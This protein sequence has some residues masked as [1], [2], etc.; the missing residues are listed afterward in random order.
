MQEVTFRPHTFWRI[1]IALALL[2]VLG[3]LAGVVVVAYLV[4]RGSATARTPNDPERRRGP[5]S[6]GRMNGERAEWEPS[7]EEIQARPRIEAG[8][9]RPGHGYWFEV[10]GESH[11]QR[12]LRAADGGRLA[13]G[14]Y[15]QVPCLIVPE[16]LNPYDKN[17][18]AVYIDGQGKVGHSSREDATEY[19]TLARR[20]IEQGA[21][22][23]C[24]GNLIGGQDETTSIGV[25]LSIKE[26]G[27]GSNATARLTELITTAVYVSGWESKPRVTSGPG[28]KFSFAV[29]EE[30]RFQE[31]LRQ[32]DGGRLATGETVTFA[33]LIVPEPAHPGRPGSIL[34]CADGIGPVGRFSKAASEKYTP[35]AAA[36]ESAGRV[37]E[38]DGWLCAERDGLG[39]KLSIKT[40]EEA[41]AEA[42]RQ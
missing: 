15:V 26:P 28:K 37:G 36:L 42:A 25:C 9:A 16:P 12:T 3:L 6:V 13:A 27:E 31:A 14:E 11:Y 17:A 34:V 21:V 10:V 30:S 40:P 2:L 18:I 7:T 4:G 5:G 20:L 38:C 33:A 29:F 8:P 1:V 22:G 35:L 39:V 19:R 32:L 23:S 24:G 41:A